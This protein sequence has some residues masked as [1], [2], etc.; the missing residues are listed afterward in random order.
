MTSC[1]QIP[2]LVWSVQKELAVTDMIEPI[3]IQLRERTPTQRAYEPLQFGV[4]LPKGAL[5]DTSCLQLSS[6]DGH[7]LPTQACPLTHWPDDSIRWVCLKTLIPATFNQP[8]F[9]LT[10]AETKTEH[11]DTANI[12]RSDDQLHVRYGTYHLTVNRNTVDWQWAGQ[13]AVSFLSRLK[14]DDHQDRACS[15]RLDKHWQIEATGPVTTILSARGWW[16]CSEGDKLAR[17]RCQ[18]SFH[19]NGLVIVDAMIHNPNRARHSGGL[20]DLGDPG[21]IHFGGMAVETEVAGSEHFRLSLSSDQPPREFSA[22]QRL[23]LHQES[24]GGENWN[25]RNH[26]NAEGQVLPRYPGYRLCHGQD[27]PQQGLRTEPVLEAKTADSFIS[28]SLPHF[29]QNFPSALEANDST[30]SAWLFPSDKR[31]AYEL[32][33][34]E[35]KTQRVVLGYGLALEQLKWSHSPLVP[36]LPAEHYEATEAFP[37]FR[38]NQQ[39][40]QLDQLIQEGLDGPSN[41]FAKREVIDEYGWRNFGEIFADHETL[42]QNKDEPAHISHYNNQYDAIYGFARQFALTGDPRWFELMDDLARHVADI[43]I[44]HTNE[45]RAEYNNGLFWHT[46]HYLDAHTATHRTFTRHN[47]SSSTPGQLGGGPAAEHCYSTGHLYH[48]WMT[49]SRDSRDTVLGLA[50][51]MNALHQGEKGLLAEIL[52]LKKQE[53]PK[54]KAMLRGDSVTSHR[55]PFTRG[56]G[57]YINTLLDAYLLQPDDGWLTQT[58]KVIRDTIHPADNIEQRNLLDTETGWSYLILLTGLARYLHIKAQVGARDDTWHYARTSFLHYT[59]WMLENEKP[60]LEEPDELE[61]ANDTW[62]AQD[63]RK[64]MLLFQAAYEAPQ[65]D[66]NYSEKA[67]KLLDYVT[68]TLSDSPEHIFARVQIILMQ[69][70]GPHHVTFLESGRHPGHESTL[71]SAIKAPTL[72]WT[73]LVSNIV[74]RLISGLIHFSPRREKAWLE[75]RLDRR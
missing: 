65:H 22:D 44:Y 63:I 26:I 4:P 20:W 64:A 14:L 60:F 67:R 9:S 15:A 13:N 39:A 50:R 70:Y 61:F 3:T 34:G 37:W 43:D 36:V 74:A 16:F 8:D 52:A 31:E 35:R 45:D 49:G 28:V 6:V 47:N 29:W 7:S 68:S 71:S 75:A 24:S 40:T 27:D 30:L 57:N 2:E 32:Q 69:N 59:N 58:E 17:F 18:L 55:Y 53:L 33:G 46:D 38:A 11:Q 72:G 21:S 73:T 51:W 12:E 56:T 1:N 66:Q 42:Y 19:A 48:H 10:L 5:K 41:F 62:T 54:L 23:S 25:S